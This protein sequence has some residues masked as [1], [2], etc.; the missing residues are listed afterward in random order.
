MTTATRTTTIATFGFDHKDPRTGEPLGRCY[1]VLPTADP[2][3]ARLMMWRR[4]GNRWAFLYATEV[5]A[6]VEK[7]HLRRLDLT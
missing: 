4:F 6:G 2:D 3:E 7:W 1:V 5:D